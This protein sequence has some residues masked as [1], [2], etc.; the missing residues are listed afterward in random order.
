MKS[1]GPD[2]LEIMYYTRSPLGSVRKRS[3]VHSSKPP[4][5]R[6]YLNSASS[7][8]RGTLHPVARTELAGAVKCNSSHL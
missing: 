1:V 6:S 3:F 5:S 2:P 8:R 4:V 7:Q